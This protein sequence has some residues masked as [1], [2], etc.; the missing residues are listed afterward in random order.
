MRVAL[1]SALL[2]VLATGCTGLDAREPLPPSQRGAAPRSLT[3]ANAYTPTDAEHYNSPGRFSPRI[4]AGAVGSQATAIFKERDPSSSATTLDAQIT[5]ADLKYEGQ[6]GIFPAKVF[7]TIFFFPFD[8]PNYFIAS[9]KFACVLQAKWRLL[10]NGQ[11]V[12]EGTAEGRQSGHFGD[13]SRGWYFVGYL[14]MP[15]P[16]KPDEWQQ[17]ADMLVPGAQESLAESLVSSVERALADKK[18]R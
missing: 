16:L 12:A 18:T 15:S 5:R 9:D 8:V 7:F 3:V 10:D 2:T 13:F 6:T 11:I 17:I 4:D 1:L 14:R